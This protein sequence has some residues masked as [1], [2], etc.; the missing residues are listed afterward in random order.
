MAKARRINLLFPFS[1]MIRRLGYQR[2]APYS[3]Y[4]T[5]NTWPTDTYERRERGGNRPGIVKQYAVALDGE[6]QTLA[7][8]NVR[9]PDGSLVNYIVAIANGKLEYSSN[10][11]EF[12]QVTRPT[13][14]NLA[15]NGSFET[16]S[17]S[18]ATSDFDN[19]TETDQDG[20]HFVEVDTTTETLGAV[21]VKMRGDDATYCTSAAITVTEGEHYQLVFWAKSTANGSTTDARWS[22]WDSTNAQY[23][24]GYG[25]SAVTADS[26]DG[27]TDKWRRFEYQII[28]PTGTTSIRVRLHS[29]AS[30]EDYV[31]FD[32]VWLDEN[33]YWYETSVIWYDATVLNQKLYIAD[34][35]PSSFHEK[36]ANDGIIAN[37]RELTS[38]TNTT[39]TGVTAGED[40]CIITGS[41]N[42]ATNGFYAI[43]TVAGDTLTLECQP[44]TAEEGVTFEITRKIATYDPITKKPGL[45]H[46][47][48]GIPPGNC[49]IITTYRGRLCLFRGNVW[50]FS[51]VND[52]TDWDYTASI[53]DPTR[54]V[55]G[56]TSDA[57]FTEAPFKA[58][59][60][61][62][63]DNMIM[64]TEK[65]TWV[66]RGDPAYGGQIENLSRSI[67]I[68][69]QHAWTAGPGG[70]TFFL[71]RDGVYYIPPGAA[72]AVQAISREMLPNEL[73]NV[74]SSNYLV[75]MEYDVVNRGVWLYLTGS[76]GGY[77]SSPTS[78]FISM[79][80][81]ESPLTIWKMSIAQM[82]YVT[83]A[84][85]EGDGESLNI[86]LGGIDGYIRT[87][88]DTATDDDGTTM[89]SYVWIGPIRLGEE[90]MDGIISELGGVLDEN[91]GDVT[92]TVHAAD[93]AE[94]AL[95]ASAGYTRTMSAGRNI[96]ETVRVRGSSAWVKITSTGR[97]AMESLW[98]V[99][100][101]SGRQRF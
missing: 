83:C 25:V 72:S 14:A 47:T 71:S 18:G 54:A 78:W 48:Y 38:P 81:S 21:S 98:A 19:W 49:Q 50:Y 22:I 87:Y 44:L 8:I 5:Q 90:G 52:P 74:S 20:T 56:T 100:R 27:S 77:G 97:W 95:A 2:Q 39:W 63:D 62:S 11:D 43:T 89:T 16:Y 4:E 60:A 67:G 32:A 33:T 46:P 84:Y 88:S 40:W 93:T 55:A 65:S 82:P 26:S 70:S 10:G 31:N 37:D 34:Y 91:S 66:L 75:N 58:A 68:V 30:T 3:S 7:P 9:E 1:G 61:H 96:P 99:L 12:T 73:Q 85:T 45:L 94:A 42:A 13:P 17:G 24:P 86:L 6:V 59:A 69:G 15:L 80:G 101:A 79:S 28:I 29:A 51:R 23:L 53:D 35:N 57:G 36:S 92:V 64:W 76:F 41:A